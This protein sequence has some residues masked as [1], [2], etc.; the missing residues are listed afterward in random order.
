MLLDLGWKGICFSQ[1]A[2]GREGACTC[3]K[4]SLLPDGCRPRE[5]VTTSCYPVSANGILILSHPGKEQDAS[6]KGGI[7]KLDDPIRSRAMPIRRTILKASAALLAAGILSPMNSA[8]AQTA[9]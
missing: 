6:L 9:P 8:L 4:Y 2:T 1:R 5:R 7:M 3:S